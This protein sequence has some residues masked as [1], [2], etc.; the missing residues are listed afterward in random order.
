MR[1]RRGLSRKSG[2][3]CFRPWSS[4]GRGREGLA[5]GHQ[6]AVDCEGSSWEV[7]PVH[8]EPE[9]LALSQSRPGGNDSGGPVPLGHGIN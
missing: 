3:S 7:D 1:V 5:D 8:C 6:L 2:S 4:E 9:D